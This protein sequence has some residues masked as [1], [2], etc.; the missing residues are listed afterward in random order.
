MKEYIYKCPHCG[1]TW[2]YIMVVDHESGKSIVT[3]NY[4]F[5]EEGQE[6][7]CYKCGNRYNMDITNSSDVKMNDF[8]YKSWKNCK[9]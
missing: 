9:G 7:T 4:N 5:I 2:K 8:I 1:D 3:K 6:C